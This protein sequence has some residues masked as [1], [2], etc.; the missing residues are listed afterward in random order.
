MPEL[1]VE[2]LSEEIP[3]RMQTRAADGL[4]RLVGA[5][6]TAADLPFSGMRTF[7][8]PRRLALAIDG[9]PA[10]QPD[11]CVERKGPRTNAPEQAIEGF[12]N[13]NGLALEQCAV[14]A[15]KKGDYYIAII[16]Q[17]GRPAADVLAAIVGEAAHALAWPKSM[18]WGSAS[19]RWVRPLHGVLAVFDGE[20]LAGA[21]DMGGA[22]MP[23]GDTTRG[24]RFLSADEIQVKDAADYLA[25]LRGA[26]V[27]VD[28][29]DRRS[30]IA[31]DLRLAAAQHDLVLRDDP[32][33]L[34]EV[35]GLVE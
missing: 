6:L 28:P 26:Y 4:A 7:V 16:E 25:K 3:A 29:V 19:F 32:G 30:R 24:H 2:F 31:E 18:R 8:T 35:A 22:E 11:R 27:L 21:L 12:L 9:I 10:A 34:D 33:L 20:P 17:R 13:A 23:F 1:L 5:A 15:D 14:R